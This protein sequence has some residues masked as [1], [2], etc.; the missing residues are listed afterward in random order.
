MAPKKKARLALLPKVSDLTQLSDDGIRAV[1]D[2]VNRV[3]ERE[4]RHG[5]IRMGT[6]GFCFAI[7]VASFTFLVMGGHDKAAGLV[8]GATVMGV[9]IQMINARI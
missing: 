8:L 6:A 1:L 7:C 2:T 5:T 4:A 3:N 9:V